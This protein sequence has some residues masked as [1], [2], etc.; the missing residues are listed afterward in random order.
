MHARNADHQYDYIGRAAIMALLSDEEV[1]QVQAAG[2]GASLAEGD[3]YLDLDR[4]Q[5]GVRRASESKRAPMKRVL[6]RK[7]VRALTW[8][9]ILTQLAPP[10][11]IGTHSRTG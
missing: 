2:T 1:R 7:S 11:S 9:K 10:L 8:Q 4:L 6:P 3:E 5:E